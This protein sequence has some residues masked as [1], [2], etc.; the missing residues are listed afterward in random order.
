MILIKT[1]EEY[2]SGLTE[3]PVAFSDKKQIS[4]P[5]EQKEIDEEQKYYTRL[6]VYQDL[7]CLESV[8]INTS[9]EWKLQTLIPKESH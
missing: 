8:K 5:H 4:H 1:A 9:S 7:V 2:S 6:M 3:E